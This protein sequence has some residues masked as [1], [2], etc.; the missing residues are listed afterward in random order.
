MLRTRGPAVL[1]LLVAVAACSSSHP[2]KKPQP[3]PDTAPGSIAVTSTA[4]GEGA[5][6]PARYTCRGDGTSPPLA[7][8][9]LPSGT[10][11]VALIV[12]DP[13][14]PAGTYT[15]WVVWDIPAGTTSI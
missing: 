12:D 7:W 13:D 1:L 15:H 9:G 10:A 4:F 8:S 2:S 6:I 11:T 14:A 3:P 5:K